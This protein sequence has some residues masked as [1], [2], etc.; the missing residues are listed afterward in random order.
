MPRSSLSRLGRTGLQVPVADW[1][2]FSGKLGQM[3][4]SASGS[5]SVRQDWCSKQQPSGYHLLN[6]YYTNHSYKALQ[7]RRETGPA[8]CSSL[9]SWV[10]R[11]SR[12]I[13]RV[14]KVQEKKS[15][16]HKLSGDSEQHTGLSPPL[17][18]RPRFQFGQFLSPTEFI[19]SFRMIKKKKSKPV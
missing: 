12:A 2:V 19:V 15:V 17:G 5:L 3:L 10:G 9:P 14:K 1:L 8:V 4:V 18:S 6:Y 11:R 13:Q 7:K 16:S